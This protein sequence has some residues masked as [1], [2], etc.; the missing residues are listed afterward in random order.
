[1]NWF[2]MNARYSP[3]EIWFLL[4]SSWKAFENFGPFKISDWLLRGNDSIESDEDVIKDL[5]GYLIL[6]LIQYETQAKVGENN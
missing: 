6:L 4:F 2:T 1:M 3:G 5:I